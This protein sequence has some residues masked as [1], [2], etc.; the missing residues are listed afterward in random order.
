MLKE[1]KN[2]QERVSFINNKYISLLQ[3]SAEES[4]EDKDKKE[5]DLSILFT[6]DKERENPMVCGYEIAEIEENLILGKRKDW[7]NAKKEN[8]VWSNDCENYVYSVSVYQPAVPI[9]DEGL[10]GVWLYKP[11][12]KT[13][14]KLIGEQ[15]SDE[16]AKVYRWL[17]YNLVIVGQSVVNIDTKKIV[18]RP[19]LGTIH[20]A[21]K[22]IDWIKYRDP[23]FSW[24]FMYPR[25]WQLSKKGTEYSEELIKRL[26][27]ND[28]DLKISFYSYLPSFDLDQYNSDYGGYGEA[29]GYDFY[30]DPDNKLDPAAVYINEK[31]NDYPR[32]ITFSRVDDPYKVTQVNNE[33]IELFPTMERFE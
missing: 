3:K 7:V 26:I 6:V 8:G 24:A 32:A 1:N 12:T 30:L 13:N 33:F 23:N 27:F 19:D 21:Y 20:D 31:N 11:K 28:G 16:Y 15:I 5:V 10:L 14:I 2:L 4:W 29:L 25:R 22:R 17:T 9:V 18:S